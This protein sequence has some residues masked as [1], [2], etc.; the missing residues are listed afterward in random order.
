MGKMRDL[1]GQQFGRLTAINSLPAHGSNAA[2][3]WICIC[4]CGN[5]AI[6]RGTDLTSGHTRSCGCL[7]KIP[8]AV[9]ASDLRLHNI[10]S[11]MK[12]RCNNPNK[13]DY[14][15]Y[16][17][18]G[19]AVCKEWSED[20]WNFFHW[21]MTHGYKAG[22]TIER[23]N[24]DGDYEPENCKWITAADQTRNTRANRIFVIQGR[25]FTLAD[26]CRIYGQHPST[27]S[28]RLKKGMTIH[29]ALRKN[30]RNKMD[31]RLLELSD[32]LRDLRNK[33]SD[34]EG[35]TRLVNG[36]IEN[37]TTEMI[38]LMTTDELTSFN[39]NGITF[40]LVTQ[41]YPAPEPD[42][43]PE[44]W[45]AMKEQGFE[46][47]FTINSQTLSATVKELISNNDGLLPAW[48][49]GLI[50]IAEKSSIRLTKT[51]K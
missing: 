4:E 35:E 40:S 7:Q 48:L 36:E 39:R 23:I 46:H 51:K 41:E 19:I 28:N 34:L 1:T 9:R 27:V 14:K 3:M 42:R 8:K 2:I 30:R 49:D 44:L 24:N 47:L 5:T 15:Y 38:D 17:A 26:I 10:W 32:K 16:G 20:F 45:D 6:I 33:K 37:V 13:P 12:Q 31:N 25:K 18:R 21:A 50:K 43:K 22:L 11:N 29:E